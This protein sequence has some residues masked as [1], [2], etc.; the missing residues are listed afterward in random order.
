[1]PD[2][3]YLVWTV[4]WPKLG[5]QVWSVA[6][7]RAQILE[8]NAANGRPT[9]LGFVS[10]ETFVVRW[11]HGTDAGL[12]LWSVKTA[13]RVGRGIVFSNIIHESSPGNRAISHSGRLYAF[14]GRY[15]RGTHL[16][17]YDLM[18]SKLVRRIEIKALSPQWAVRPTGIAFSPD[19]TKVAALFEQQGN[20]LLASWRVADG[21]PTGEQVFPAGVLPTPPA[22]QGHLSNATSRA[23]A[24]LGEG[25]AWL[26]YGQ[27]AYDEDTGRLLGETGVPAAVDQRVLDGTTVQLETARP[28]G[29]RALM[30]LDVNK[31]KITPKPNNSAAGG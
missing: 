19:D 5:A 16:F 13:A 11:D 21:K 15:Q 1:S 6:D 29:S 30:V 25:T 24:W 17:V 18:T 7:S 12:E 3:D 9:I 14:A 2:G 20:G 10:A 28:D 26:V 23:L 27:R 22:P 31:D 4:T 8:F